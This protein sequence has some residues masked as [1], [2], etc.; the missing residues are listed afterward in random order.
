M[1]E[2]GISNLSHEDRH[3]DPP[4][5][6]AA[7]A[8]LKAEAYERAATDRLGFWAEQ[9]ERIS[10]GTPFD[11]VLGA[12]RDARPS[13]EERSRPRRMGAARAGG[14]AFASAAASGRREACRGGAAGR[15]RAA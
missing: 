5:D 13:G 15:R 11:E 6:L 10:W 7:H 12:Y 2:Q 14:H 4:A 1:S 8:N 3:F 9:A